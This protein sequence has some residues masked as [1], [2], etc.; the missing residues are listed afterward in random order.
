MNKLLCLLLCAATV[1][2]F[3]QG[4]TLYRVNVLK[5]KQGMRSAFEASWKAHVAKFHTT[6]DKR[7]VY[8]I[9][10]GPSAGS[11]VIV[12]GP[13]SYADM[14]IEKPMTKEHG[15]D[16][17]KTFS[18][19]IEP[20]STNGIYRNADTLSYHGD[21][22][23][24]LFLLNT[25]VLKDGK[26]PEYLTEMRRN[27]LIYTKQ[28]PPIGINYFVKQLA[29]NKPTMVSV[30][31]LKN[32][33]K[34]MDSDYFKM[35]PDWF[36]NAYIADYGQTAW[37]ARQKILVDDVESREQAFEKLRTDLSSPQ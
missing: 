20:N 18:S 19:L 5:P 1:S 4:K 21:T 32:G 14:D 23:A 27:V 17:E 13:V 9:T 7:W 25:T 10:S 3:G 11:Y 15:L 8:E 24:D 29:G 22:K 35:A 34:E 31:I 36:K 28:N 30:R 26:T 2:V 6:T 37:D 33:Y 12:E 16:M